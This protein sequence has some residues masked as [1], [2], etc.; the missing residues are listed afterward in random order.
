[1]TK[2]YR[3]MTKDEVIAELQR[4]SAEGITRVNE[5]LSPSLYRKCAEYFGGLPKARKAAGIAFTRKKV[6]RS[7]EYGVKD[8][9]LIDVVTEAISR[10]L[11]AEQAFKEYYGLGYAITR[12]Y[13]GI[14]NFTR[15]TGLS[16]PRKQRSKPIE[17]KYSEQELVA[18][19]VDTQSKEM[20]GAKTREYNRKLVDACIRRWGT[21]NKALES[22]GFTPVVRMRKFPTAESVITQYVTDIE[23]GL[24][25]HD[26]TYE[27]AI[28]KFFGSIA[29]LDKHL[30]LQPPEKEIHSVL[31]KVEI[32]S[33]VSLLL[34]MPYSHISQQVLDDFDADLSFSIK[35]HYGS[36]NDYFSNINIDRYKQ[37]YTPFR[38]TKENILWQIKR[39][40]RKGYPV[41]YTNIAMSHKGIIV[42]CRKYYGGYSGAFEALGLNYDDFCADTA[43]ASRQGHVFENVLAE[44]FTEIGYKFERTP[45]I[46][47]CH[48]DFVMGNHWI[49]AKLSEWTVHLADCETI[50]KYRPH[51][52]KL[53]IVY[54]RGKSSKTLE[55]RKESD[56]TL[57][58]ISELL[59]QLPM[60]KR[61]HFQS[62]LGSI[63]QKL[64]AA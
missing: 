4:L 39:W 30:G 18:F 1:M 25:R 29:E 26:I 10:D 20:S 36:I 64:N 43:L 44:I 19:I 3:D 48:P 15:T 21:W 61:S 53:T 33:R 28:K 55:Y 6:D 52:E 63:L 60:D 14:T 17:S 2:R 31:D 45:E 62:K 12:N 34:K 57:M 8:D 7:D 41:N 37:P 27:K 22:N 35:Q 38:W 47:G 24:K 5:G 9:D 51:C 42:A 23:S 40:I 59:K 49:D 16:F 58:H 54:L 11:T 13:G 46:N 32:A 56:F 50:K